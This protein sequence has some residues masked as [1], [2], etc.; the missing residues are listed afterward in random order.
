LI[1][2]VVLGITMTARTPSFCADSA[3]PCAWLPAEAQ[4]T[5]RLSATGDSFAI[6]L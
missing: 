1:C 2:G 3:T 5:P 6:L 4:I